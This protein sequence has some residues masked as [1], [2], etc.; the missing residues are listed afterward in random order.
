MMR[1]IGFLAGVALTIVAV[2]LVLDTRKG[3][4]PVMLTQATGNTSPEQLARVVSAIAE[5]VDVATTEIEPDQAASPDPEPVATDAETQSSFLETTGDVMAEED[6]EVST[7]SEALTDVVQGANV[8]D[9]VITAGH[10]SRTTD[11]EPQNG[12]EQAALYQDHQLELPAQAEA[13]GSDQR[14]IGDASSY[15]FW[16]PFRSEWSAQGFA[17]RLSSATQVPVEVVSTGPGKY[18]VAF[19]YQDETERLA[20]IE[21]IETITGLKLE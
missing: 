1:A 15:L 17:G 3:E 18:R 19:S 21:R 20:R 12:S 14:S 2:L 4:Q 11:G 6:A 9:K 5:R 13:Y 10:T 7:A 8:S 16:S